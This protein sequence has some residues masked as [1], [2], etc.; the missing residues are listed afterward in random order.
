M[1]VAALEDRLDH[2]RGPRRFQGSRH[3][4]RLGV[5]GKAGMGPGDDGAG[6]EKVAPALQDDQVLPRAHGA[7]HAPEGMEDVSHMLGAGVVEPHPPAGGGAGRQPG[8]CRDPV[9][10]DALFS[11]AELLRP[12]D[13]DDA[14]ARAGD[15]G[16]A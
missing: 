4:R 15:Q 10:Q 12:A 3:E 11:A 8:G 1:A 14:A 7:A 5:R 13:A 9:R 16:A 6:A 2:H